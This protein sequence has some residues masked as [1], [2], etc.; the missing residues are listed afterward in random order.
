MRNSLNLWSTGFQVNG[1]H[2]GAYEVRR[3]SDG[4]VLPRCVRD[5]RHS[6]GVVRIV[7]PVFTHPDGSVE[8]LHPV[9]PPGPVAPYP[10]PVA[11]SPSVFEYEGRFRLPAAPAAVWSTIGQT[12]SFETWWT[13]LRDLRVEGEPLTAGSVL[14]GVVAPPLPYRMRLQV[15][16]VHCDAPHAIDAEVSGDLAGPARIRLD[17]EGDGTRATVGWTVELMQL[18]MRIAAR[19]GSPL[20]RWGHD[21]VVESTVHRFRELLVEDRRRDG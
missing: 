1:W 21:R 18:P 6:P 11:G 12:D 20:L 10:G 7:T 17:P 13:W 14:H 9:E 4:A 3:C 15:A 16:L 2:D 19:V 5:G 8:V